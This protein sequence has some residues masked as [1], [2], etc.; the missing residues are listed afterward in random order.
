MDGGPCSGL[1]C[2]TSIVSEDSPDTF[3]HLSLP[4]HRRYLA[5]VVAFVVVVGLY[6]TNESVPESWRSA[7]LCLLVAIAVLGIVTVAWP[8]PAIE[9]SDDEALIVGAF[10]DRWRLKRQR[11]PLA[12]VESV[13]YEVPQVTG[14]RFQPEYVQWQPP[15]P[16]A[17][18]IK[19]RRQR[20]SLFVA[21]TE[22]DA[23]PFVEALQR[24]LAAASRVS[25]P[26]R[27]RSGRR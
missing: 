17:I 10:V 3:A 26:A 4:R 19:F 20:G 6:A 23:V 9:V 11:I 25:T 7:A 22:Y 24:R 14:R 15:G 12:E 13:S 18:V 2:K 1:L 21:A 16:R 8:G 27:K 5:A